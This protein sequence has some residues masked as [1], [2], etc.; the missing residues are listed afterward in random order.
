GRFPG[1]DVLSRAPHWDAVTADVVTAR[2]GPLP[3]TPISSAARGWPPTGSM[4]SSMRTAAASRH[5][6]AWGR[7][8]NKP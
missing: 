5:L 2:T 8:D 6:A 3:A 1:F 4:G 7:A